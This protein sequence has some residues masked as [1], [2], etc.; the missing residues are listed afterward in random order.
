MVSV[1]EWL[2]VL[3]ALIVI[4]NLIACAT[5]VP[6]ARFLRGYINIDVLVLAA[7][8]VFLPSRI[9]FGLITIDLLFDL[10]E[11]VAHIY[12]FTPAD[13]LDA[14]KYIGLLPYPTL[15]AYASGVI[16]YLAVAA[17]SIY[18]ILPR[19]VAGA[20]LVPVV[21]IAL[22]VL[23]LG[24]DISRGR[25]VSQ[26]TDTITGRA[27]LVR[28]PAV[29]LA[30][31]LVQ[32]TRIAE[33]WTRPQP[34]VPVDS[35]SE[36]ILSKYRA[37]ILDEHVN[38]VLVLVE[39]WGMLRNSVAAAEILQS[40]ETPALRKRYRLETGLVPFFGATLEGETRELCGHTFSHGVASASADELRS[41]L[42]AVFHDHGYLTVGINNFEARM[43]GR[44]RWFPRIGFGTSLFRPDLAR[45]GMRTCPGGL[46][47][48]CDVDVA[49][50]IGYRLLQAGPA[51]PVFIHWVTLN[52][53]IPFD[54]KGPESDYCK[55][56]TS[57]EETLC[58]WSRLVQNAHRAIA[59]VASEERL[60]PTVFIVVGDHAPPFFSQGLRDAFS[61]QQVPF[62]AL[63]PRELE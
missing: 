37:A 58:I 55:T 4:P 44:D 36:I 2:R 22:A 28:M 53:H 27:H 30:Y 12:Y 34:S 3:V 31:T 26:H 8:L 57:E 14:V 52:S 46:I 47:G 42:P 41:C 11:P 5:F 10:F 33:Y 18:L 40:Y 23:A 32:R 59:H 43:Y 17:G 15:A 24:S 48:T 1:F 9:V 49:K 63:V 25:Y 51:T 19:K 35:A 60:T 21:L 56:G 39:S 29:V 50:F 45:M 62:I 7:L 61:Q 13:A 38:V 54:K 16:A 6:M 20:K